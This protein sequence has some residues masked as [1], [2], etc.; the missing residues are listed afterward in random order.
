M[1]P[2]LERAVLIFGKWCALG[3]AIYLRYFSI[4]VL[5][6]KI[7]QGSNSAVITVSCKYYV[8]NRVRDYSGIL[9]DSIFV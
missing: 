5:Q 8:I 9:L 2:S 3:T 6:S 4:F 7:C 1:H